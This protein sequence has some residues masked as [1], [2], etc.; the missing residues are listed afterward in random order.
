MSKKKE[1]YC[2]P[3]TEPFV[4]RFEGA[5]CL[6]YGETGAAGRGFTQGSNIID[7]EDDF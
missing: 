5:L 2:S 3:T 6:S 4:V 7:E 1:L